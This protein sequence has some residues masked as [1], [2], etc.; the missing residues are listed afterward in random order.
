MPPDTITQP[1]IT[2]AYCEAPI[3]SDPVAGRLQEDRRAVYCCYGCRILGESGGKSTGFLQENISSWFKILVAILVAGQAML[4]SLAINLSP[5]E[6]TVR[7]ILHGAL[8]FSSVVVAALL[9]LP[10]LESVWDNLKAR[11]IS[12]EL[13]FVTGIVGAWGTSL[14][15]TITGSGAVYYEVVAVLLGVYSAGKTLGAQ[16]RARAIAESHRLQETFDR[17]Q[18][19]ESDG[20]TREVQVAAIQP[21]DQIIVRAGEPI[22]VDGRIVQGQAFVRVTPLTGEPYPVVRREGDPVL[23]GSY[24]EDGQL[25]IEATVSGRDRQLDGLLNALIRSRELPSRIQNQA[26]RIVKWFLPLV[27]S[28]GLGTFLFWAMRADLQTGLFNGMAVLLVACPCAL[29][30]ATPLA[31]WNV[32]AVLATRGLAIRTSR[33]LDHLGQ[34][35]LL[36]FDKTGTLSEE[37]LSLI[38]L[39]TAGEVEERRELLD[40]LGAV[41]NQSVHPVARAFHHLSACA[42]PSA[43]PDRPAETADISLLKPKVQSTKVIPGQGLEA[44]V[45]LSGGEERHLRFGQREFMR[46]LSPEKDLL[47]RLNR[48]PEDH[49]IHIEMEGR[50]RAIAAVRERLRSSVAETMHQARELNLACSVLTGDLPQ[51]AERLG[52]NQVQGSLTPQAKAECV[53]TLRSKGGRV[54]FVGDGINDAPAVN[55]ADVGIALAH[56]AGITTAHADAVLFGDDLRVIPWA[57]GLCRQVHGSIRSNLLFAAAYN[58]VGIVLAASG[59]LHP[60]VASL[61]MVVSSFTVSWRA[62]RGSEAADFCCAGGRRPNF[63]STFNTALARPEP[64]VSATSEQAIPSLPAKPSEL[65]SPRPTIPSK[66]YEL[67]AQRGQQNSKQSP[68]SQFYACLVRWIGSNSVQAALFALQI[69]FLLYLGNLSPLPGIVL[70]SIVLVL[71]VLLAWARPRTTEGQHALTMTAA[72]LGLGNW[73]MIL[74]WWADL[75][76]FQ[77]SGLA[78]CHSHDGFSWLAFMNMPWMY[79]GM[80]VLGLPPMLLSPPISRRGL[81]RISLGILA[82]AGMVWGMAYGNYVALHWLQPSAMWRFVVSL[83]GMVVGMLAGMFFLCE[84]GRAIS[85]LLRSRTRLHEA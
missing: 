5:P 46:D 31:L 47:D 23:A 39:T 52:L 17:C 60:V 25:R 13:L 33:A 9:G 76:F 67:G 72:M 35:T 19:C 63:L 65:G 48:Q 43:S 45:V 64:D 27:I 24:S 6:G 68:L 15:S 41:Q 18:R 53:Q 38:D 1:R 34:L 8:F 44:W 37:K 73:G 74:G 16:S 78:C 12:I 70:G 69:P 10:L 79:G 2:C 80:L 7:W 30:L 81:G 75:G 26:D 3:A 58:T 28:I 77:Y 51:R 14:H 20:T 62:L 50:L 71:A 49:L 42:I 40:I 55:A 84:L 22:P 61:L 21:G 29:G 82:S 54:G 59:M 83:G 66:A 85:L 32:M 36:V 56:G 4:L 11:R 57:V